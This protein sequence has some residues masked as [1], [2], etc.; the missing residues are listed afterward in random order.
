MSSKFVETITLMRNNDVA[1]KRE[2]NRLHGTPIDAKLKENIVFRAK[3]D[4]V[5]PTLFLH[6]RFRRHS[7]KL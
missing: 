7:I 6:F 1:N 2:F 4:F 3:S 5:G